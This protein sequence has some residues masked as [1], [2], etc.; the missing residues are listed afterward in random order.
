MLFRSLVEG[1]SAAHTEWNR[2]VFDGVRMTEE[3]FVSMARQHLALWV[4]RAPRRLDCNPL[5][6]WCA[7]LSP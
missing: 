7:S 1:F 2:L 6:E 3:E 4:V 5:K